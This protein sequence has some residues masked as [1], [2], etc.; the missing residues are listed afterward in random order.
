MHEG[1]QARRHAATDPS[2]SEEARELAQN[3]V[4]CRPVGEQPRHVAPTWPR[5]PRG[6]LSHR[7]Y[8]SGAESL[9]GWHDA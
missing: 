3:R 1:K 4:S 2:F 5:L 7:T 6:L 8:K 9:L